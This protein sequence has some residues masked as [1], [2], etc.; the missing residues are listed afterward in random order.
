MKKWIAAVVVLSVL[1]LALAGCG[2]AKKEEKAK[3]NYPTKPIQV[4]VPAGAGGDTD[5]YARLVGKYIEKHLGKGFVVVNVAGAGGSLGTKKV[6]DSAADGHTAL[7]Y[8]SS[9]MLNTVFGVTNY[10]VAD[11]EQGPI[12]VTDFNNAFVV[13]TDSPYKN[14]KDLIAAA[15]ANPKQIIYGT[16]MGGFTYVQAIAFQQKAGVEMNLVD[17]G[18]GAKK[19][20]ALEGKQAEVI[21]QPAGYIKSFVDAGK[22]RII[23][24]MADQRQPYF[25]DVPTFKEQGV[26]LVL[27]KPYFFAF[28]KGTPKEVVAKFDAAV[29]KV[30]ED[31]EFAKEIEKY[32]LKPG[33]VAPD[34]ARPYLL[35]EQKKYKEIADKMKK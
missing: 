4:I 15:K 11:F 26:D 35:D 33:Y 14:L 1:S 3:V 30:T 7:F 10:G 19:N 24:L 28:P 20:A 2:G 27:G 9:T 12:V 32:G 13:R 18:G 21:P 31:P 22:F 29:K 25:P 16:E 5:T 6:M 23:G 17:V 34:K 8:H